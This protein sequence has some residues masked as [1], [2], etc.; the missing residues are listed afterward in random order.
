VSALLEAAGLAK[1]FRIPSARRNTVRDH[2]LG[3][4]T[5]RPVEELRVLED[6]SLAVERGETVGIVGRNGSGKS[7]LLKILCGIYA[8]DRGRIAVRGR[9]APVLELGVGW[10][11]ELDAVDNIVLLGT[12]MGLS[13]SEARGAVDEILDFAGLRRFAGL[14]LKHF[15]S[16]MAARL[17]YSV[18]FRVS[19]EVLVLDEVFAVG[20]AGF[21]AQCE[22]RYRQH[23]AGG[24]SGLIVSHDPG[25]I[26]SHCQRALLLDRGRIRAAGAPDAVLD[27]YL[28]LPRAAEVGL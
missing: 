18:A 7:T 3:L 5:P 22:A 1:S 26:T 6:V 21:R 4:L 27:A 28:A 12:V 14:E 19:G 23:A 17:A 11:P 13:L 10:N 15:S 16:G 20:D 2:V 25:V 9:L 24:G 8:A